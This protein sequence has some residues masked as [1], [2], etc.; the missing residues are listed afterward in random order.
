MTLPNLL[1]ISRLILLPVIIGLTY[2]PHSWC[3]WLALFLFVLTG[4]SD[5]VDGALA[6]KL[7]QVSPLGTYLDP[8]VD[9]I[10]LLSLFFTLSDLHVVPLWMSLLML[11]REF[12]VDGVRSAGAIA[13]HVVGANFM[14]KTKATLQSVCIGVGLGMLALGWPENVCRFWLSWL[15][16]LTLFLAWV[17]AAIF[18]WWQRDWLFVQKAPALPVAKPGSADL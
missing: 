14:G 12:I 1:T 8:V 15:T 3:R 10:V 18:L 2:L 4:I 5:C 7:N 17:F 11:A 13:G 6:R 9:K 16:G